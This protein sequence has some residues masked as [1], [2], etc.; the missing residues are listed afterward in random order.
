MKIIGRC[1][2][3]ME[4]AA[5]GLIVIL[6][7]WQIGAK[8]LFHKAYP[9]SSC[10]YPAVVMSG[11]MEPVVSAGDIIIVHK[12]DAYR[13][14]DIVTFSENGN[15]ITHRIVEETP[16]GFVTKGDS[17]NAPDGGIVAGDSIHGRMAA[18]IPGAGYAVLFFRKPVGKLAIVLLSILLFWGSDL[19][20]LLQETGRKTSE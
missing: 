17:N 20:G 6:N 13:P 8:V 1:F 10:W 9:S 12:E 19:S 3:L 16:E 4:A 2:Y 7:F 11:S 15:L 5:L 14:G 18:V